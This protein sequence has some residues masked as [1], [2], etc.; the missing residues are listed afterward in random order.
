MYLEINLQHRGWQSARSASGKQADFVGWTLKVGGMRSHDFPRTCANCRYL[1]APDANYCQR[2]GEP[3]SPDILRELQQMYGALKELDAAV[4]A[5]AGQTTV[6]E[7]R[8]NLLE[9]YQ[10][11]RRP[12]A[13]I[14]P[15]GAAPVTV[16][17]GA[18]GPSAPVVPPTTP[19]T[20]VAPAAQGPV[21]TWRA[22]IADQ[23][24]AIMAYL[25]GFLLLIATLTFEV[26][27]WSALPDLAKLAGVTL[28]Y[29]VF[30]ALGVGL[31]H[32]V[33][34]R[35]V[36]RIYLGVFALM[37]PLEALAVYR[38]ELQ[39]QGFSQAGM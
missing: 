14:P 33:T 17:L 5:G 34:L 20:S 11:L 9:R 8:K 3:V 25:G 12:Q 10:T 27:A 38:F 7:F 13:P 35:T 2:C 6:A 4:G 39:A 22:F 31:R 18:S 19:P 23:A 28:V 32:V 16:P 36:S 15:L 29:L 37:T 30:G 1:N 24:I 26:S 21:F